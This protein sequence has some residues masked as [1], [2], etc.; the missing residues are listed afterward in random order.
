MSGVGSRASA[1]SWTSA[2]CQANGT[3]VHYLRSGGPKPPVVRLHGLTGSGA[4][5]LPVAHWTPV[6]LDLHVHDFEEAVERVRSE[7]GQVEQ[8][9]RDQGPMPAAFCSDPFGN[10][11]CIIGE[12]AAQD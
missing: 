7:G 3:S 4:C 6:H 1:T 9:Y 8:V 11:F 10:G 5:W 12:R 2:T